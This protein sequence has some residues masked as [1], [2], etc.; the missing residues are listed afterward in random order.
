MLFPA[1]Q[2]S[3]GPQPTSLPSEQRMAGLESHVTRPQLPRQSST[4]SR[5]QTRE[6]PA[7][8]PA[9]DAARKTRQWRSSGSLGRC[10]HAPRRLNLHGYSADPRPPPTTA[11]GRRGPPEEGKRPRAE[12]TP[13]QTQEENSGEWKET[14]GHGQGRRREP[15]G[16]AGRALLPHRAR[17][18]ASREFLRKLFLRQ[19]TYFWHSSGVWLA[20]FKNTVLS[21]HIVKRNLILYE[22]TGEES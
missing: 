10:P 20:K 3:Q 18:S 2:H 21:Y 1:R 9:A 5:G 17:V 13:G 22:T 6:D 16:A 11:S 14:R 8:T 4:E 7:S 12:D 15:P 19:E